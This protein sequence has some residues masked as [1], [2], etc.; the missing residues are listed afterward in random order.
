MRLTPGRLMLLSLVAGALVLGG[1]AW[2]GGRCTPHPGAEHTYRLSGGNAGD[3]WCEPWI[4]RLL[5]VTPWAFAGCGLAFVAAALWLAWRE[6]RSWPKSD[7]AGAGDPARDL[8][9]GKP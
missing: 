9:E 6:S 1:G 7:P 3:S 8:G 4:G 5:T 2:L